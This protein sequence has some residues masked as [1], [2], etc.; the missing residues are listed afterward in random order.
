[1]SNE[2]QFYFLKPP[3]LP[4]SQRDNLLG[5]IVKN[6]ANPTADYTPNGIPKNNVAF[7]APPLSSGLRDATSVL[8]SSSQA[9]A[10]ALM[11][12]L[13]SLTKEKERD[14]S[15]SFESETLEV[16]RLQQHGDTF[17]LLKATPEVR[18]K[19]AKYVRIGG[20]AYFVVG[21]L[22]WKDARFSAGAGS[23]ERT[24]A[25]AK[26]PVDA[27]VMAAT[28]GV[29][30]PIGSVELDVE[31]SRSTKSSLDA[32]AAGEQIIGVEYR[33]IKREFFGIGSTA[34]VSDSQVRYEGGKYYGK[35]AND[36]DDDDDD[37][38]DDDDEGPEDTLKGVTLTEE[39]VVGNAS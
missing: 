10:K 31:G 3:G 15:I 6:Y 7:P 35:G 4:I 16:V 14:G 2:P 36:D 38:D 39:A 19:L 26:V 27:A 25:T 33:L 1:M 17:D 28:G 37:N 8:S 18:D 9:T 24:L 5:R 32:T 11:T 29:P 23:S 13:A 21:L 12:S 20:R 22:I 30:V 34:K